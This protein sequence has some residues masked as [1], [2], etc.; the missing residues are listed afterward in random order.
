M[1]EQPLIVIVDDDAS[2]RTAT[3]D[4]FISEGFQAAAFDDAESFL[5]SPMRAEAACVVTDMRMPGINGFEL[6]RRIVAS[7]PVIPTV[8]IT[9]HAE[10]LTPTRA[11][12]A[13]IVCYLTKPFSPD[14]LVACVRKAIAGS[15]TMGYP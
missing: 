5:A 1:Q 2:M 10:D 11:R 15:R 8:L 9:G 14:E 4:L 6:H 3:R 7:K 13:G 12:A